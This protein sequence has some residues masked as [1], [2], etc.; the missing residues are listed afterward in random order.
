MSFELCTAFMQQALS[1][2]HF[3]RAQ[4]LYDYTTSLACAQVTMIPVSSTVT[5][6]E[7]KVML[8]AK[9]GILFQSQRL[10][11][12]SRPGDF[13]PMNI[14]HPIPSELDDCRVLNVTVS[15]LCTVLNYLC[16]TCTLSSVSTDREFVPESLH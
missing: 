12:W 7:F 15:P 2:S 3:M 5:V 6:K 1:N 13:L 14:R 4:L 11:A 8:A 10:W 9:W 16:I